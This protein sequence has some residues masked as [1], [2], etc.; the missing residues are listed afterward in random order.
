MKASKLLLG[1][2][3]VAYVVSLVLPTVNQGQGI[4]FAVWGW[5]A[6]AMT[7]AWG[8]VW[9]ANPAFVAGG[10]LLFSNRSPA[11]RRLLAVAALLLALFALT[12]DGHSG[13]HQGIALQAG[14]W[15]WLGS[16]VLLLAAVLLPAA[17]PDPAPSARTGP[18]AAA[19]GMDAAAGV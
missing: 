3:V 18:E 14:Y 11:L 9:L 1:I 7:R 10:W 17:A 8:V 19:A 4:I 6:F 15:V 2:A 12:I 5:V 16:I 13:A